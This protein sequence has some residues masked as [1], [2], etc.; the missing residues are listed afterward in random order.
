M[1]P[2]ARRRLSSGWFRLAQAPCHFVGAAW[3]PHFLSHLI[4]FVQIALNCSAGGR[5]E[6]HDHGYPMETF[7]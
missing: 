2:V 4:R 1:Q 3:G 6:L 5:V 7:P